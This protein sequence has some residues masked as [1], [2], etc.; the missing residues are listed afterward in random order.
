MAH[1]GPNRT[2]IPSALRGLAA[3]VSDDEERPTLWGVHVVIAPT[4]GAR[5]EVTNGHALMRVECPAEPGYLEAFPVNG[6][7][8][9]ISTLENGIVPA[10]AWK[11]G[12]TGAHGPQAAVEPVHQ[13]ALLAFDADTVTLLA[14][15]GEQESLTTAKLLDGVYPS[16]REVADPTA[17]PRASV[18]L[19]LRLL[20]RVVDTWVACTK[21][22]SAV[23]RL[24]V[25]GEMEM[26]RFT[27]TDPEGR[28]FT[29]GLM[30]V[31]TPA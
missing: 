28:R 13:R 22:G 30:P 12:L 29:A 27:A 10:A 2:L 23:A 19:D 25:Y 7:P 26:I 1:A 14:H 24:E 16:L 18:S 3:L 17:T 31:R 5:A 21:G 20:K 11:A 15:K 4:G 6:Q 9:P 8:L